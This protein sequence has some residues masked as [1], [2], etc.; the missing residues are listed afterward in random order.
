MFILTI[1]AYRFLFS[2]P[3]YNY[4]GLSSCAECHANDSI[5][6]Q[7]AVWEKSPHS[8]AFKT[9]Q[10]ETADDIALKFNIDDPESD[11][12]CLKC[13]TTGAGRTGIKKENGVTCEACHGPGQGYLSFEN[14]AS[15]ID[16]ENA[17]TKAIRN[18]M[19]PIIGINH[20]RNREKLCMK[21]HS[22]DPLIRPCL[23]EN[24]EKRKEDILSLDAIANYIYR[25]PVKR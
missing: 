7:I 1:T 22:V 17:Y 9:L 4:T 14:H 11:L 20:I 10:T 6:N 19:Y 5:G 15:F 25:H 13:H 3:N 23:P 8:R 2:K 16:R 24:T 12:K 18:G 21:C